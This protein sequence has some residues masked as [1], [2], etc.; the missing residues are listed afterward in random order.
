M[1]V[2]FGFTY[3]ELGVILAITPYYK[4]IIM[5]NNFVI[6]TIII[7]E[8]ICHHVVRYVTYIISLPQQAY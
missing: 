6:I 1:C 8:P 2:S 3:I 7:L 5:S 4:I